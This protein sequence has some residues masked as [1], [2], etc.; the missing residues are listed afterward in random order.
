MFTFSQG[1][2]FGIR[3]EQ[4]KVSL[5]GWNGRSRLQHQR[6]N[7]IH[8][9]ELHAGCSEQSRNKKQVLPEPS[10]KE[11]FESLHDNLQ[12]SRGGRELKARV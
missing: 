6:T 1:S 11:G 5:L 8:L 12:H 7:R 10:F 3:K 9:Q 4:K 2:V